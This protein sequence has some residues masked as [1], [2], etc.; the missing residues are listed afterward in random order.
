MDLFEGNPKLWEGIDFVLPTLEQFLKN[1]QQF[2][3]LKERI[4]GFAKAGH[5]SVRTGFF[6]GCSVKK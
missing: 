1:L 6:S 3:I 4:S 2:H 5:F